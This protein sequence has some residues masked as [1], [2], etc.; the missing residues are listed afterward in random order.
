MHRLSVTQAFST[1]RCFHPG[2]HSCLPAP[3]TQR[4]LEPSIPASH[5]QLP[6]HP[7]DTAHPH[8]HPPLPQASLPFP[9]LPPGASPTQGPRFPCPPGGCC[10][11]SLS[12]RNAQPGASPLHYFTSPLMPLPLQVSPE[13]E[14]AQEAQARRPQVSWRGGSRGSPP[15]GGRRQCERG[16]GTGGGGGGGSPAVATGPGGR[17]LRRSVPLGCLR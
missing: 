7:L 6:S 2:S 17:G 14:P 3:S 5:R 10:L 16:G 15:G 1:S 13:K 12:G 8:H 9:P 4:L 11:G